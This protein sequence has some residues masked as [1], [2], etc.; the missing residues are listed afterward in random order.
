MFIAR[1]DTQYLDVQGARLLLMGDEE[2]G[3][4]QSKFKSLERVVGLLWD[5]IITFLGPRYKT[6]VQPAFFFILG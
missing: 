4:F 6:D 2:N 3:E 1:R 5:C